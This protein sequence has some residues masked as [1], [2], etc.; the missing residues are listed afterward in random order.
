ME[1]RKV[2][3]KGGHHIVVCDGKYHYCID[4]RGET[5]KEGRCW[6]DKDRQGGG[7]KMKKEIE[8]TATK[9]AD[10]EIRCCYL[11][12]V[13]ETF[14]WADETPEKWQTGELEKAKIEE[15]E[16]IELGFILQNSEGY[17]FW[18]KS[19]VLEDNSSVDFVEVKNTKPNR[20]NNE[21]FVTLELVFN[22]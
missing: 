16:A 5:T 17:H 9:K 19:T 20:E 4:D 12:S 18:N 7:E 21:I 22:R 1:E 15:K 6:C 8:A 11:A 14:L 10:K 3:Y 13:K 2:V